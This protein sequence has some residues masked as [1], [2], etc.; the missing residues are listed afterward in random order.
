MTLIDV[1]NQ[2]KALEMVSGKFVD[3]EEVV[4]K[5]NE[6]TGMS[7]EYLPRASGTYASVQQVGSD[8]KPVTQPNPHPTG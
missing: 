1:A 8:G 4:S 6:I 7:M 5:L 2:L 3:G